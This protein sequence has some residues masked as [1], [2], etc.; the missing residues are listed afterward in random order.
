[1]CLGGVSPGGGVGGGGG[2]G[3]FGELPVDRRG[4]DG[5]TAGKRV[6]APS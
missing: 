5:A 1:M 6:S 3:Q 4:P 2:C